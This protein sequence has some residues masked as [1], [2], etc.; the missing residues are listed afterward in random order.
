M[1]ER[2]TAIV[3]A[4]ALSAIAAGA[5]LPGLR[6]EASDGGSVIYIRNVHSQPLT[7]FLLE[8]VDYPGS[9][10]SY[11]R[12]EVA[13]EPIPAGVERRYPVTNMLIGAAPDYVKVQAALYA[14]GGSSGIPERVA[15]L[16]ARRKLTLENTRELIR[17]IEVA[18]SSG[19]SQADLVAELKQW[20]VGRRNSQT[21]ISD[22]ISR[23]ERG[24]R[25]DALSALRNAE[26]ALAR[27]KPALE[28]AGGRD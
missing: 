1:V 24:S 26:K 9:S 10:F 21:A 22:A 18:Q 23:L 5:P 20:A 14:D 2:I 6:I 12:D 17:R 8:L 7:A 27:S 25:E 11:W 13:S 16:V 4:V 15:Q 3:L 28:P 19:T